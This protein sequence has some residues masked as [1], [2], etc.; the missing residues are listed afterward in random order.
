MAK[1]KYHIN[2]LQKSP[3]SHLALFLFYGFPDVIDIKPE[4]SS[5]Y[6][7]K[8][9]QQEPV[10]HLASVGKGKEEDHSYQSDVKEIELG[11][12]NLYAVERPSC[13]PGEHVVRD[14]EYHD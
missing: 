14:P 11:P 2:L 10:S 9:R 12:C 3:L 1:N 6:H 4:R 13:K 7:T 8:Y 5:H